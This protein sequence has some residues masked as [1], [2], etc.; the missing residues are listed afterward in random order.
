MLDHA[1]QN[2][3][4]L[5]VIWLVVTRAKKKSYYLNIF[6]IQAFAA[7]IIIREVVLAEEQA[8]GITLHGEVVQLLAEGVTAVLAHVR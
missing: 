6:L 5:H 7:V 3:I 8:A 4:L 1:V 2:A